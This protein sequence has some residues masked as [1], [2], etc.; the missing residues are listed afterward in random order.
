MYCSK[1]GKENT[2][3]A[4]FCSTC[5]NRLSTAAVVQEAV[6]GIPQSGQELKRTSVILLIFLTVITAGIYYPIWFLKRR[7]VIN[8][9]QSKEKL[10]SGVF[11]FAIVVFSISLLVALISGACEELG[12][13]YT[14]KGLD[15]FSRIL[16]LVAGITLL[17]QCFKVRRI[18]NE[19]FNIHLKRVIAFSGVATFFFQ[20]YYLQY[21]VNRF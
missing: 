14:A 3:T 1:C 2:D 7:N 10:N 18:F 13:M 6:S 21:K 5:G 19:H 9:L 20:I 8:S 11:I 15:A 12:E 17:V 4:T 16:D